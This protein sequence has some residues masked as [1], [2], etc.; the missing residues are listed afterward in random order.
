MIPVMSAI[1]TLFVGNHKTTVLGAILGAVAT[2]AVFTHTCT[3]AE[4]GAFAP[5]WLGLMWAKDSILK[6]NG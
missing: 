2:V 4:Y 6:A 1:K 3:F 5:V